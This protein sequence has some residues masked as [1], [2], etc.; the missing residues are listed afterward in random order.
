[1][2]NYGFVPTDILLPKTDDMSK[3]SCVACDQYTSEPD[4]WKAVEDYVGD[5]VSTLN[6]MLPEIYLP[7]TE[8]R[9]PKITKTMH[10]YLKNGVFETVKDS[11]IYVE[12]TQ[13]DGKIRRGLVGAIDLEIYD[14]SEGTTALCRPTEATVTSRLPARVEIRKEAPV[15]MPHIMMLIDDKTHSVIRP[16]ADKSLET[17]YDFDLMQGGGHIKGMRVCGAD[18]E[19]VL[20]AI[21]TLYKNDSSDHPMLYA[22]G[23]GNHSLAAA[24]QYYELVKKE[25]G[26]NAKNHPARYALVE[27]VNL[28][29]EAL[30]FEP[31]H[32]VFFNVDYDKF[33]AEFSSYCGL[34]K[35]AADGQTFTLVHGDDEQ[36]YTFTCPDTALTVGTL[37]N[38]LDSYE[39]KFGGETDY[40]H[41]DDVVKKLCAE[42]VDRIGFIVG[43]IEKN[44]FF[45]VI[46]KDGILPRK[47]FSMGHAHDKRF[48]LECRN[49]T[50]MFKY[51]NC[52]K[53]T[54]KGFDT[55]DNMGFDAANDVA[56]TL[57]DLL[58]KKD[59]VNMIFAAAPSQNDLLYH[60]CKKTDIA[61]ERV[62]A[63]HMDEYIGLPAGAPQCFSNF[64]ENAVFS[65]LPFKSVNKIDASATDAEAEAAR[66]TALLEKYPVDI[67]CL[68]I[69]ENGHIAF[70]DPGVADFNDTKLVKRAELDIVCRQQQV[71]DGCFEKLDDV[72]EYALTLTVPALTR[73]KYMFC[74]VPGP[75]KTEAV[76]RMLTEEINDN[77]PCTILRV[78]DNAV[79]YCDADSLKV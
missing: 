52:E 53:L 15:E 63:F 9:S 45:D 2:K 23:D 61:W 18:A 56:K 21:E 6:I 42:G 26:K 72:P 1:M 65:K 68:G 62:N 20:D 76:T 71:N 10:S 7:E 57:C 73:A 5:N 25:L 55:R 11:F 31:I 74:V 14:F 22:M 19:G 39:K 50:P 28:F 64:L 36:V 29:D 51:F 67:V 48:Y 27:L 59:E 35:G 40:I 77:C 4:Y 16:L 8:V 58:S 33:M 43:G 12:R 32:R 79:L 44:N 41:G 13:A 49:I 66:Y 17:L 70:N 47:T 3:W 34:T 30:E 38:F 78:H 46:K 60:L 37:Q 24:K 54:V 69:G 75:T